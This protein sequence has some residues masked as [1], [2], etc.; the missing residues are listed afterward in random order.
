MLM[1]LLA[2]LNRET[3]VRKEISDKWNVS[4]N[5]FSFQQFLMSLKSVAQSKMLA[6]EREVSASQGK[7]KQFGSS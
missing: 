3:T 5:H 1:L 2:L 4:P 7:R 6:G